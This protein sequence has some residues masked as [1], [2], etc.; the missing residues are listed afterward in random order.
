MSSV[1][2]APSIVRTPTVARE[3]AIILAGV[4][5]ISISAQIV[6]PLPFTPVPITGQTL[7]AL[8]VGGAA[9]YLRGGTSFAVYML[10]GAL[11]A[12][13]FADGASGVAVLGSVTG[14]YLVGM[15]VAA[16]AVGWAADRGWDRRVV[17]ALGSMIVA[18]AIV[19]LIGATWLSVSLNTG[20][21]KTLDLGVTPFLIGDAIKIALAACALPAAWALVDRIRSAE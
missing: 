16:A 13:V 15:L 12:P 5:L 9:G 3:I 7:G 10:V 8:L 18:N 2:L 17:P 19:Y 6:V 4:A 21:A 1:A 20:V 14:G 11:G